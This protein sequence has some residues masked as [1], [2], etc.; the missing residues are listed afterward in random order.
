MVGDAGATASLRTAVPI[1]QA[2]VEQA[3]VDQLVM[4][5]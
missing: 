4:P 1:E 2:P 5:T 3:P